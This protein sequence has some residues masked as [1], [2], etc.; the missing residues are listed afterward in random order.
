MSEPDATQASQTTTAEQLT[1][2]PQQ[3]DYA[4]P[5]TGDMTWEEVPATANDV[6]N[7]SNQ[8]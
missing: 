6:K 3:L 2:T 1:T 7:P 8:Q 4:T 5:E